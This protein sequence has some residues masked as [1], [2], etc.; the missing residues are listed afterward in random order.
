MSGAS[1]GKCMQYVE[2]AHLFSVGNSATLTNINTGL[3]EAE[4]TVRILTAIYRICTN[5]IIMS[6]CCRMGCSS[7]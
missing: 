7:T 3:K 2:V 1:N 6:V 5:N 4:V